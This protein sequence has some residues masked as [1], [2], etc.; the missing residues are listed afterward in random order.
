[1][2][3]PSPKQQRRSSSAAGGMKSLVLTD[4]RLAGGETS[5]I[6]VRVDDG[7]GS[8]NGAAGDLQPV[9]LYRFV[10]HLKAVRLEGY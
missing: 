6:Q 7:E 10:S 2:R 9:Q 8:N 5:E 3:T 1:M 4:S